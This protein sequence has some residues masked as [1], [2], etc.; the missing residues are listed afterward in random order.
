MSFVG[1]LIGLQA[2]WK[3]WKRNIQQ[4]TILPARTSPLAWKHLLAISAKKLHNKVHYR[5]V[6]THPE[7]NLGVNDIQ[8]GT[9]MK[10]STED[11]AKVLGHVWFSGLN[12][13]QPT[14]IEELA[15]LMVF[16]GM[17]LSDW[18]NLAPNSN[19]EA[20][21]LTVW[22]K[23]SGLSEGLTLYTAHDFN[24]VANSLLFLVTGVLGVNVHIFHQKNSSQEKEI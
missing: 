11:T 9:H 13:G 1:I 20:D 24:N 17:K 16:Q 23:T 6:Y 22:L 18:L 21:Y 2:H 8:L 7:I 10:E 14:I 12:Y 15:E 4:F 19:V 5:P 3:I